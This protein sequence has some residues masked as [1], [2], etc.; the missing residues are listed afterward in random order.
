MPERTDG[1]L[2]NA[3]SIGD[4]AAFDVFYRRHSRA[5]ARYA[6]T[7]CTTTTAMQEIVQ[8]TFITAWK[9]ADSIR[10]AGSS[11]LPW[12][13]V[14][15][16]NHAANHHR[17]TSRR[18]EVPLDSAVDRP[19][20]DPAG[21][22]RLVWVLEAIEALDERDQ[23]LCQMC[24]VE[25]R[26]YK[27]AARELDQSVA[28]VGKRL[29]RARIHLRRAEID[30]EPSEPP[31]DEDLR[32]LLDESRLEVMGRVTSSRSARRRTRMRLAG[33]GLAATVGLG[34]VTAAAATTLWER[35]DA[36][37]LTTTYISL[38]KAPADARVVDIEIRYTCRPGVRYEFAINPRT[39]HAGLR[40]RSIICSRT[41]DERTQKDEF[42]FDL[43][44]RDKP[45][46]EF[47]L[48]VSTD[49]GRPVEA[50]G[51]YSRGP[52][53]QERSDPDYQAPEGTIAMSTDCVD[54][55]KPVE[56][57]D[58]EPSD[59]PWGHPAVWPERYYV[60]ENGMTIG[61]Y[62]P[63]TPDAEIPDLM[64]A[65]GTRGEK[66]FFEVGKPWLVWPDEIEA[67]QKR[68]GIRTDS[69]GH[70]FAPLYAI[71][72]RTRIGWVRIN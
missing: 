51:T 26:S 19:N 25:G 37:R 49:A 29:Q 6:W 12:L 28:W 54:H 9:K 67:E 42:A 36:P 1:E 64:P 10:L 17:K 33:V 60:N 34:G 27:E 52:T 72:G 65:K 69:K 66:G 70:M 22:E 3:S 45:G 58:T 38:G 59:D 23:R 14:T 18:R 4:H 15:C 31:E 41:G 68:L 44:T 13:L 11:A 57:P 20:G 56:R 24:L 61:M 53:E 7:W 46:T 55:D 2:L 5:V 63:D 8:D 30:D 43:C 47:S 40:G 71:D 50:T 39:D 32:A 35:E 21:A 16:R 62:G 48:V